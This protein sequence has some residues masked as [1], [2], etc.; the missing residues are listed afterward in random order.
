MMDHTEI[1]KLT[2][3]EMVY[4]PLSNQEAVW[5]QDVPEVEEL[6][7]QSDFYMIAG[8]AEARF[9]HFPVT[10]VEGQLTFDF[11]IGNDFTDQ[12]TVYPELLPAV[13]DADPDVIDLELGEKIIRVLG[14]SETDDDLTLLDWFTTEKLLMDRSRGVPG[15]E[16][17]DR[18]LE[19]STYELL[20]VGIAKVGDTFDRLIAHGH[21]ARMDLLA[22]EPQR[23][24]G[25]SVTDEIYLFMFRID[26]LVIRTFGSEE[27]FDETTFQNNFVD[28]KRIVADVEKAYVSL[29]KPEYNKVL[30]K[31]YPRGADG[32]FGSDFLRYGYVIRENL[33]FN[34]PH[35]AIRGGVDAISGMISNAADGIYIE[36]DSVVLMRGDEDYGK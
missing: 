7:R 35:G 24:P 34:T 21:K 6:L 18:F 26:P 25:A 22:N 20:Y 28:H 1:V 16:G 29:L 9:T 13:V 10:N 23:L 31:N 11:N 3:L 2:V 14:G 32:L 17:L 33:V 36:G 30:F 27:V 5:I 15:I 12:V 4:P 19:A 8:R